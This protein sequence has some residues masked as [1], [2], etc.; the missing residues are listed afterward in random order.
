VIDGTLV[1]R[2]YRRANAGRW[3]VSIDRF[4]D[5]LATSVAKAFAGQQPDGREVER[6]L[7]GLHLDDLGLAC[8]CAAGDEEAWEHFVREQRPSLYRAADAMEPGGGARD[9]ADS[10]Y[11]DLFGFRD[12]QGERRSLFRYFHGRS[13]LSTWLRAVLSQRYVD[14]VRSTRRLEALP[15]EDAPDA[16]PAPDRSSSP[17]RARHLRLMH[18]AMSSALSSLPARDRVRL[19]CYYAQGLTL[20]DTGRLLGEH[21]ATCSRQLARARKAIREGVERRLRMEAGLNEAEIA[22]CFA[23]VV[24]DPGPLDLRQMLDVS[25]ERKESAP[26]RSN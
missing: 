5:A 19:A 18:D 10:L 7:N 24:E 21:E 3:H 13:S 17:D 25:G 16:L 26:D 2:L 11:A 22:H 12:G 15:D 6:Y 20:A 8:A 4:A 1:E 14:R 9:L 23:T